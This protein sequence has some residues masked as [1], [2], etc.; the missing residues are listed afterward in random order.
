MKKSSLYLGLSLLA[1]MAVAAEPSISEVVVSQPEGTRS[2]IVNYTLAN[3]PAVVTVELLTNGVPIAPE[4]VADISGDA[5]RVVQPGTGR[6]VK[7]YPAEAFLNRT[8]SNTTAR[9]TAWPLGAPPDYAVWDL[10]AADV[11]A[12][13]RFYVDAV[14]IPGGIHA[15]KYATTHLVMRKIPAAGV[16]SRLGS[17][18][19]HTNLDRCVPRLVT[20]SKDYYI[21]VF[22]CTQGQCQYL[23]GWVVTP[24][25]ADRPEAN[26]LPM[27]AVFLDEL[28]GPTKGRL[29]PA[30]GES[31][32]NAHQ[33]DDGSLIAELR[34]KTGV[35]S[36]DLPTAAQ[37][38]FAYRGG[39]PAN[40][41]WG[42]DCARA[43]VAVEIA[44][45]TNNAWSSENTS[46]IQPVGQ[47]N[48]NAFGLYDSGGN[49]AE[50]C[51]DWFTTDAG[52]HNGADEID[53]RGPAESAV[54]GKPY[55]K[56]TRVLAGGSYFAA[57]YNNVTAVAFSSQYS[58]TADGAS[59]L[60]QLGFRFV[61]GSEFLIAQ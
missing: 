15:E 18:V 32:A 13:L 58:N 33:V 27:N 57:A 34:T 8:L 12:S 5:N 1:S 11:S 43:A 59:R 2:I 60:P 54:L 37:W 21:G 29:W 47:L 52:I 40:C 41:Y 55:A 19:N 17:N 46:E 22:E 25:G 10:A 51:L 14:S 49:V 6:R 61:C 53:P 48:A 39:C 31:E 38:E 50:A 35:N 7:W 56:G 42:Y 45:S 36:F 26:R 30:L 9:V 20:L 23:W 3:K 28:R 24:F 4:M 16:T 44:A